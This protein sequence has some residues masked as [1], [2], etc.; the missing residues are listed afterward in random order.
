M[1]DTTSANSANPPQQALAKRTY[2]PPTLLGYG[3]LRDITLHVGA[4]GHSDS[5]PG[6]FP[7]HYK[8]S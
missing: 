7:T 8:T 4:A 5:N 2:K 1:G 6:G 3:T